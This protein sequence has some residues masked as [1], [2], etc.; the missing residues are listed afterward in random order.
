[1]IYTVTLN[2]CIDKTYDVD[3][4]VVDRMNRS[5][6]SR[7]DYCGKGVN[8][9][10]DCCIL[11]QKAIAT[12]FLGSND[13]KPYNETLSKY[14]VE[15]GFVMVEG[16][17]RVNIKIVDIKT[18][19]QTDVNESGFEIP[20]S[21]ITELEEYLKTNV[22]KGDIVSFSGSVPKKF[23]F[24]SFKRLIDAVVFNGG[25]LVVDTE[26]E[27]LAYGIKMKAFMIKPNIHEFEDYLS[28][29]LETV[30]EI[31]KEANNIA[32]TGVTNVVI[33][34]GGDGCLFANADSVIYC[35]NLDV[36]C[37]STT[38]AGDSVVAGFISAYAEGKAFE[39]CA[40]SAVAS[41]SACVM[42]KGTLP[43]EK[44]KYD[45]LLKKVSFI[46]VL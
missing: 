20:V 40:V 1:M 14:G 39:D 38:G 10:I 6:S 43:P 34:M 21:K 17:T 11:G 2:P 31:A 29:K 15:N 41:A 3:G 35:K 8:V 12:G 23:S 46:R 22:K 5:I 28:K 9:A 33:S 32:K 4:L 30:E 25:K 27:R 36:K 42:T 13:L 18:M 7:T 44:E 19:E 26:K 24:E 45:E 37:V 16:S